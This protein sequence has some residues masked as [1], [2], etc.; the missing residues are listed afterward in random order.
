L[1]KEKLLEIR[2]ACAAYNKKAAKDL[3]AELKKK[4]WSQFVE[5]HLGVLAGLLLHSEFDEAIKNI[6]DFVSKL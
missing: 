2:A 1:L 5:E 4:A 3:L 6:E